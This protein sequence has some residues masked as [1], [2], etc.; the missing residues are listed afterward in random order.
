MALTPHNFVR[1]P[2]K[3]LAT[4]HHNV[5]SGIFRYCNK[6]GA[7][8]YFRRA[9]KFQL[10]PECG[11][12][13]RVTARQR[14]KMLTKD[15]QEWDADLV[16]QNPLDF[17]NYDEK[18]KKAQSKTK[19]QDAVLTG[20]AD[21]DGQTAALGIM[22]PYFIMGS[23]GTANGERITRLFEKATAQKL[24]VVLFTASG[25]ARMQ[26]G[27]ASLMQMAKISQAVN[28]HRQAGLLYIAVIMDPTTGGVTAS[29]ASQA[30]I[31]LAEPQALL[32]FAGQRV[33]EQ[34]IN[35]K[36]PADFQSVENVYQN[37]F[38]DA[39]VPRTEQVA[40]LGQLLT[41]FAAAGWEGE[42]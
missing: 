2:Q 17:P 1:H 40:K 28:E 30:D 25:G 20:L 39:I 29:F 6:C 3:A 35:K 26:E 22:D 41:I 9:G 23:L 18:L 8:F 5:P 42:Q 37:G 10:C 7:K 15:F 16:T 19:L 34:T 38:I 36:L 31:I 24:P 13:F 21:L 27:I 14:L 32:G 33:I 4:Y 11:Y 12:G